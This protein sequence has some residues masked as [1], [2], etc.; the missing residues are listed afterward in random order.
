MEREVIA[1]I[2]EWRAKVP[3]EVASGSLTDRANLI[4]CIL[5]SYRG[6]MKLRLEVICP[7]LGCTMRSLEREFQSLYEET[8]HEFQE[9]TRIE[10]A[11]HEICL[12][13][14]I[15]LTAVAA[16][17]GYERESEFN[18]FFRRKT[19]ESPTA[20]VRKLSSSLVIRS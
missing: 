8:M 16:D 19:G 3:N 13:P 18:R 17:L 6:N 20:F 4:R 2:R 10:N 9:R 12:N 7:A 5:N 14:K 11:I 1:N 15:K